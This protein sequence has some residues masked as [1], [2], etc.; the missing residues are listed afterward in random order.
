MPKKTERRENVDQEKQIKAPKMVANQILRQI[1]EGK[2]K[3]GQKL[4]TQI[5]LSKKFGVGMSS[6]REAVN[7]LEVM[8]YL[9]VTHGSGTYIRRE[10]PFSKTLMEKLE[11]DLRFISTYEL[12]ELRELLECHSVK[13][14]A[15]RADFS[16][17]AEIRSAY[18]Q[19]GESR[20]K[21]Q[22]FIKAD[23]NFHLTISKA[24]ENKATA[25][26]IALIFESMHKHFDLAAITQNHEYRERAVLT[27]E[28]V[29]YHIE[30]G[31]DHL[32]VRA[33]RSHLDLTKHASNNIEATTG[34]IKP[35]EAK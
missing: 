20:D 9:K 4:P 14:A 24:I 8:G 23:L 26:I 13:Q 28:Q 1:E 30:K 16:A 32:A 35:R 7:V 12:L 18:N 31:E 6:I 33:M 5:E 3:P 17:I 34:D 25:A 27:A 22:A 29:V 19:L 2:L 15:N 10:I 11:N 21:G